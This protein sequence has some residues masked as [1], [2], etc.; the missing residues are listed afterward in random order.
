MSTDKK[1]LIVNNA[2]RSGA[3]NKIV[4]VPVQFGN[5]KA[6]IEFARLKGVPFDLFFGP[7]K[8]KRLGG[9]SDFH[10]EVVRLDYRKMKAVLQMASKYC[11]HRFEIARN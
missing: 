2:L 8:R 3:T 5:F 9:V 6:K 1:I 11:Q 10:S 7:Q 4:Q